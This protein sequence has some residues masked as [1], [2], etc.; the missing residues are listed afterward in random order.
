MKRFKVVYI[1]KGKSQREEIFI[2]SKSQASLM[3][4]FNLGSVVSIVEEPFKD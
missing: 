3:K 1:P 4:A 2:G